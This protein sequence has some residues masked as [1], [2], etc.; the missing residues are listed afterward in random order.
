MTEVA[1]E[2]KESLDLE[3]STEETH[4]KNPDISV[5]VTYETQN[6]AVQNL[7]CHISSHVLIPFVQ[8]I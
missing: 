7:R 5:L 3:I 2:L 4:H 8:I 6:S 1:T